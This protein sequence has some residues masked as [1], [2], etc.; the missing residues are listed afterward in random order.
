MARDNAYPPARALVYDDNGLVALDTREILLE[1]G[2]AEVTIAACG[3]DA[4]NC[5]KA[6]GLVW[7]VIDAGCPADDLA[8]VIAALDASAVPF[9]LICSNPD[10]TDI[11]PQWQD[12]AFLA[13]PYSK[14][15]LEARAPLRV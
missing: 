11:A 15:E 2:F 7:A 4:V 14:A 1:L 12:R 5:L 8:V 3:D 6:N 13:R 9:V 10:G